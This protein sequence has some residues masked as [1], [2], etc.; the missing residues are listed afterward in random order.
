MNLKPIL[1]G[2]ALAIT[3]VLSNAAVAQDGFY[4]SGGAGLNWL[5]DAEVSTSPSRDADFDGGWGALGALGYRFGNWRVE[6]EVGYRAN[7]VDEVSGGAGGGDMRSLSAMVNAIYE[8]GAFSGVRPYL[9]A[10]IGWARVKLND[11]S[12]AGA[13]LTD[14]ADSQFAYQGLLGFQVPLANALNLDVGY[15]YFATLDPKFRNAAGNSFDSEYR[16]HMV[17]VG[18]TY[19]FGAPAPAPRPAAAPAPAPAPTPAPPAPAA[20]APALPQTFIVFFDHDKHDITNEAASILRRAAA[21][22]K[23]GQ[24][25]RIEATGHADRSGSDVY[26]QRLSERRAVAVKAFLVREGVAGPTIDTSGKGESAPL[27]QTR[28]GVRE[29]Q[30]RRVEVLVRQR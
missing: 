28:D 25:V 4:I 15:R 2:A 12:L 3:G 18:L 1:A 26:N 13:A 11:A 7:D 20:A 23:A 10:G 8:L 21:L 24:N 29:P 16:S 22:A 30:N 14:D 6:G 27:V 9:G 17:M 19:S 5:H